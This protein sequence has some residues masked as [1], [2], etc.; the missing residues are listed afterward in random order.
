MSHTLAVE[1][2]HVNATVIT[3]NKQQNTHQLALTL[4]IH[5]DQ[6]CQLHWGL[7][8]HPNDRW[9]CPPAELW[10][11]HSKPFND[12]A[13]RTDFIAD[14]AGKQSL[15]INLKSPDKWGSL[16]F[17]IYFPEQQQWLKN[18]NKDFFITLPNSQS[19]ANL[20]NN[21]ITA[22]VADAPWKVQ[23]ITLDNGD[24]LA[25][26]TLDQDNQWQVILVT[27]AKPPVLLHWGLAKNHPFQWQLPTAEDRPPGTEIFDQL[28]V[29]TP[30]TWQDDLSW[31]TLSFSESNYRGINFILYQPATARW[32]KAKGNDLHLPLQQPSLAHTD[33]NSSA[34][35]IIADKIIE[36]EIGK[37]SWTLMHRFNLA[38]DLLNNIEEDQENTWALLFTWLRYSAIRQLDWQRR[39]NTQPRELSHAQDR[40]TRQL[41]A[42]FVEQDAS[43]PWVR[44]M[45]TTLGRGGEGQ[46]VRDEILN[47]MHRHHLKEVHGTFMEEWH[48]KLHNNT[49]PDDIVICS[50]YL[51]FLESDGNTDRFYQV[52]ADGGIN[53]ERLT[54]FERPIRTDPQFYPDKKHGLIHDFHYFLRILNAVHTGTDL[55]TAVDAVRRMLNAEMHEKINILLQQRASDVPANDKLHVISEARHGLNT[56]LH[57]RHDPLDIRELLYLDLALEQTSRAIIEQQPLSQLDIT[58]LLALTQQAL[59][60]AWLSTRI[61]EFYICARH[62]D[63]LMASPQQQREWYLHAKAIVDRLSSMIGHWSNQLYQTLQPKAEY[64]GDAFAADQWTINLFSE[65]I[66][67]STPAF[68]L[69]LVLR[70]LD[71]ML[72]TKAG[73]SGWQ[74]ISP[75]QASG[76]VCVVDRLLTVQGDHFSEPTILITDQVSGDEEIPEGITSIIT[77]D[78]PDLV[79]HVAVRARNAHVLFATCF[80]D[81]TYQQ[82]KNLKNQQL[83]LK[84][85]PAGDVE[86]H[87]SLTGTEQPAAKQ[88][89]VKLTLR[90]R[91]FSKWVI[92]ASAFNDDHVGGKSN[93]LQAL[94]KKIPAWIQ[95]PTSIA[96][97]FGVLEQ[98]LKNKK[99][100]SIAQQL[101]AL[102]AKIKTDPANKLSE[103]R[104]QFQKITAPDA[105]KNDLLAMWH[106]QQLADMGWEKIW[107]AIQ[108]VW[109]SQWN[110]RAYYS[111][112]AREI[113][114]HRLQMAVLIQ[115]VVE[116]DYAFVI[117]TVNP[118]TNNDNEIY[119]EIVLGMGE[120]L[121]GNYPGRAFSFLY[122]KPTQQIEIISYPSKRIG[123]YGSGVIF[124]SDS[125]GEDLKNY[126]GAGLY[127]SLLATAPEHRRLDYSDDILLWDNTFREQLLTKIGQIG[128]QIEKICGSPQDIEGAIQQGIFYVVQTRPQV[129][130]FN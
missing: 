40:L 14:A 29:R 20:V 105:L 96:L 115:Q 66:I 91:A 102:I 30:F 35:Q 84:V 113:P 88:N 100:Q 39:Y 124:R 61:D 130:I 37:N 43:R 128:H 2:F 71:P 60:Q 114:H 87:S 123:L 55:E 111:R 64:L 51:A 28:A 67:R 86:Y 45:L 127:D 103:I 3:I 119:V 77:S 129:G 34:T 95:L 104:Q 8:R 98:C 19:D 65:E 15:Q 121:V 23:T 12:Q 107:P 76:K 68:A 26:A 125:N 79:S 58:T 17:V 72:R 122:H 27:N 81:E 25:T 74:V 118:I 22:R 73:L 69:S 44:L 126:A 36:A 50:A 33:F 46:K 62:L 48:Q 24:T 49:T 54:R 93:N 94:R 9:H 120:T 80:D 21:A 31:L 70:H 5:T 106:S 108:G 109:A 116:A 4:S 85:T 82:L 56:L 117:H 18:G 78:T 41:A 112:V 7:I 92:P 90:R 57:D 32:L 53:R 99:N 97:P 75:A 11:P 16:L 47:I 1:I 52:L 83:T 59:R 110:E 38:H 6:P 13:V 89:K 63:R 101:P 42:L 10:P